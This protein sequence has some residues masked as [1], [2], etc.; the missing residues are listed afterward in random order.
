[1]IGILEDSRTI[2]L[3]IISEILSDSNF[4]PACANFPIKKGRKK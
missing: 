2:N 1:M 3:Q 4:E